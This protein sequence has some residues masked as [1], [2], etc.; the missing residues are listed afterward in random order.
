MERMIKIETRLFKT[1]NMNTH[2]EGSDN[3]NNKDNSNEMNNK[4]N[5]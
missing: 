1:T 5:Y 3:N 4:N 2:K